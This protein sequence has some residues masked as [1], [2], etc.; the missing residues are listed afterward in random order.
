[1][2]RSPGSL[3]STHVVADVVF[4]DYGMFLVGVFLAVVSLAALCG[5][6]AD[7]YLVPAYFFVRVAEGHQKFPF[8][9]VGDQ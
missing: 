2:N 5:E 4:F 6:W 8:F 1:M 3:K 9:L 7:P